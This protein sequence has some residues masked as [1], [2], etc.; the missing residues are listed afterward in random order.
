MEGQ[1]TV[2]VV[3]I[4]GKSADGADEHQ[5][6]GSGLLVGPS[7]VLTADHV[8]RSATR[9]GLKAW[10]G[11]LPECEEPLEV[12]YIGR[13][14]D[15]LDACLLRVKAWEAPRSISFPSLL[16]KYR[17]LD[18]QA[19]LM[20]AF[21]TTMP[22]VVEVPLTITSFDNSTL[23]YEV[24]PEVAKGHSGGI[25]LHDN[26]V[27]A[28]VSRR[29]KDQPIARVLALHALTS[30]IRQTVV[31]ERE[32]DASKPEPGPAPIDDT[33]MSPPGVDGLSHRVGS[34]HL[35]VDGAQARTFVEDLVNRHK[36]V[37]R[38][39]ELAWVVDSVPGPQREEKGMQDVYGLHD[40]GDLDFF[41]TT[42][43]HGGPCLPT[44][45]QRRA[46]SL[47]V[48]DI[49]CELHGQG[50][51]VAG[52]VVELE[53]VVGTV[54]EQGRT[55]MATELEMRG[56]SATIETL[57]ALQLFAPF[58]TTDPKPPGLAKYELH[59]S[60]DLEKTPHTTDRS[61]VELDDLVRLAVKAGVELGG[62]FLFQDERRWAYRSNAFVPSV[63]DMALRLR[64]E[65]LRRAL[66]ESP[67]QALAKG[68]LRLV[69]E[70]AL[71]VW[72][73][74]LLL[75]RDGLRSV[76][77]LISWERSVPSLR[78][79]W[80][81]L[82]NFLGDQHED[83]WQ[84][85]ERN[86]NGGVRYTYFLSSNAD[87]KRWLTFRDKLAQRGV[88]GAQRL[89]TAYVVAFDAE[90]PLAGFAAFIANQGRETAEGYELTID[91]A[92]NRVLYGLAM[93]ASRIAEV[94]TALSNATLNSA[95]TDWHL[96]QPTG[97]EV[98][99]TA[100]CVKLVDQPAD[101]EL[102]ALI[103]GLDNCLARLASQHGGSVE[104]YG[105]R[106]ITAVFVG[107]RTELGL[108]VLFVRRVLEETR[109]GTVEGV[110]CALRIGIAHG[111][112][113][114][115]ARA[116]GRI[117]TGPAVRAS[118]RVLDKVPP[119]EGIFVAPIEGQP[120]PPFEPSSVELVQLESGVLEIVSTGPARP[121]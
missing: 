92:S 25:I 83:M 15:Q 43:L 111:R 96:V 58:N 121:P 59:F 13:H 44:Q 34:I 27:V 104:L 69:A 120:A 63:S 76:R 72:R 24:S 37:G 70:E 20:R 79:F 113:R 98:T 26:V 112:A 97:P 49:L 77:D 19:V 7:H 90:G 93:E 78:E 53:R 105:G 54:D 29:V 115:T 39:A 51:D 23:E 66:D 110:R 57:P 16:E 99:L 18:G 71:A 40:P 9:H 30:W 95:L 62:W 52:A 88:K 75:L 22:R 81:V 118:H 21:T 48:H 31:N 101:D 89:M 33:R 6:Y 4:R 103:D 41:S 45:A 50:K 38:D 67:N 1:G 106:S 117:W 56:T 91:S 55:V 2:N 109:T 80:V 14:P 108:A 36:A 114:L 73:A 100:V 47:E 84:T 85:M 86:L 35:H 10:A 46:L 65:R 102:D 60:I 116:S 3:S 12:E 42:Q 8:W 68:R 5:Y 11:L 64:W 17:T 61:P 87:A 74:P 32:D 107:N 94:V 82:P 119:R 28:L